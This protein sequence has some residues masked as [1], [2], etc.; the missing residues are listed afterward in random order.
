MFKITLRGI[1]GE[2]YGA[3]VIDKKHGAKWGYTFE[4]KSN[5]FKVVKNYNN[6]STT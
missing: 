5:I 6:L 4:K 1:N 3:I 2:N